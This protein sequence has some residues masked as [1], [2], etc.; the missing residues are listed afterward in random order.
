[1]QRETEKNVNNNKFYQT[2]VAI[3][4]LLLKDYCYYRAF[5]CCPP[6]FN[7]TKYPQSLDGVCWNKS[8]FA[9]LSF[10]VGVQEKRNQ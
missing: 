9:K 4:S 2:S 5:D 10:I 8:I 3:K 6:C 7:N 1:M